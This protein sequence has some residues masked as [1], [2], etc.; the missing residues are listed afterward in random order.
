MMPSAA[1]AMGMKVIS[2]RAGRFGY[3]QVLTVNTLL[4]GLTI[5]MYLVCAAGTP[6]YVIVAIG[7]CLG[8]FNSLQFSSMNSIAYADVEGP[9]PAWPAPSPVPC[10]SCR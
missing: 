7:L 1:A 9:I 2:T 4:I 6:L 10:S 5:S 3:R 8:F